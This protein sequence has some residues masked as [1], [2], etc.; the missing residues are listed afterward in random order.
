MHKTH[1][2]RMLWIFYSIGFLGFF[3][4]NSALMTM[5]LF[6]YDPSA[7]EAVG[8]TLLV[9]A[10]LVGFSVFI[11]RIF[12]A[13]AQPLVGYF[14]D[15]CENGSEQSS[16]FLVAGVGLMTGAFYMIFN[17]LTNTA[18]AGVFIYLTVLL[19]IYFQGMAIYQVTYLSWLPTLAN[20]PDQR[21]LLSTWLAI[22]SSLGALLGSVGS[23]WL[24]RYY[25]FNSM[26]LITIAVSL[27]T[28][29]MPLV[30]QKNIGFC[31]AAGTRYSAWKS[32][33][34]SLESSVF[35]YYLLGFS[36]ASIAVSVV[37]TSP[38]FF[39]VAIFN[40]DVGFT[41]IINSLVM[42]SSVSGFVFISPLAKYYGKKN[43]FQLSMILSGLGL[44]GLAIAS[45]CLGPA[46]SLMLML[47]AMSGLGIAGFFV[48]PNA[49][50]PDII[51]QQ[52]QTTD[53]HQAAIYFG[54]RGLAAEISV[55]FGALLAGLLLSFG[56][57]ATHPLG[58]QLTIVAASLFAF[59]S[60]ASFIRY[61]LDR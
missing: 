10:A 45:I 20:L 29:L 47:L 51:D 19:L 42:I 33:K 34:N 40:K 61:P 18:G 37:T 23:P 17:P 30:I 53:N 12:G 41:A 26:T 21:V 1:R 35:R 28:L 59:L 11:G 16:R 60:A 43:T 2:L 6:R 50:L 27:S 56:K 15:G 49:M 39:A 8:L 14:L 32:M 52:I 58:V 54:A 7:S 4:I 55:G 31:K 36:A 9:P 5:L 46:S 25:S 13:V 38:T 48:L 44:L 3:L 57:T 22:T 24:T